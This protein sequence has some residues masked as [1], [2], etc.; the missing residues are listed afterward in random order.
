LVV[1]QSDSR[2]VPVPELLARW[3]L[4]TVSTTA[5]QTTWSVK[6][7]AYVAAFAPDKGET[8]GQLSTMFPGSQLTSTPADPV[9]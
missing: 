8:S 5:R 4:A 6:A 9:R 1:P 3:W 2:N 7:L